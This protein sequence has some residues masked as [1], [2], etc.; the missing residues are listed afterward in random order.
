MRARGDTRA[1]VHLA[2]ELKKFNVTGKKALTD[3][4]L[5]DQSAAWQVHAPCTPLRG[6]PSPPPASCPLIHPRPARLAA[7]QAFNKKQ[8][9]FRPDQIARARSLVE[10]QLEARLAAA[11]RAAQAPPRHRPRRPR[12]PRTAAWSTS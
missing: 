7:W 12:H 4:E 1:R 9:L 5:A 8:A 2:Q 3:K 11:P 6:L 10:R